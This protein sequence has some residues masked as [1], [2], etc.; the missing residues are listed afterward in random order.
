MKF[1]K[2]ICIILCVLFAFPAFCGRSAGAGST[3]SFD[4]DSAEAADAIT[5]D[6]DTVFRGDANGDGAIS[7][8]DSLILKRVIASLETSYDPDGA[9]ANGDGD[10]TAQDCSALKKVISCFTPA[11]SVEIPRADVSFD[12]ENG[13]AVVTAARNSPSLTFSFPS[14]VSASTYKYAVI[15]Y[16]FS[17]GAA[18]ADIS[19]PNGTHSSFALDAS[20][21]NAQRIVDLSNE[22]LWTGAVPSCTLAT[23]L[24]TGDSLYIEYVAFAKNAEGAARIIALHNGEAVEDPM[25]HIVFDSAEQTELIVG[26]KNTTVSYSSSQNAAK[27]TVSP[28]AKDPQSRISFEGSTVS[29]DDYK[30]IVITYMV[31]SATSSSAT[32]SEFFLC[33]GD[34]TAPT[35]GYS[36]EFEPVKDG[37]YHYKVISL[38]GADYWTGDVHLIRLDI[39]SQCSVGDSIYVDSICLAGTRAEATDIG[40]ERLALR[41]AA[42][43]VYSGDISLNGSSGSINYFDASSGSNGRCTFSGHM[44]AMISGDHDSFNRFSFEYSTNAIIRGVAYY[45]CGGVEYADEFFLENTSGQTA[46]FRSIILPYFEEEYAEELRMIDFYTINTSSASLK[47]TSVTEEDYEQYPQT[48]L[49]LTGTNFKVGVDMLMGG[50]INYFEDFNDNNPAYGNLLNNHDVGRLV[51]QS[52]YGIDKAPYELGWWGGH[53]WQYNPVQGGDKA[54]NISRIVDF[55]FRG[56]SEFY[57][58]ARPMDWGQDNRIT[59]SYMENVYTLTDTYLKIYNIFVDFSGYTHVNVRQELPAFYTISAL[60]DFYYYAGSNPWTGGSLTKKSNL[61]FWGHYPEQTTFT[62]PNNSEFWS[63]WCDGNGYGIGLYVPN[64]FTLRA[65][66]HVYDGSTDPGA[67]STNYVSPQRNMTLICGKPLTYSYLITA[68]NV[69]AIRNVFKTNHG[70]IGNSALA[71]YN[72]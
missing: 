10:I 27:L 31:P 55:E 13:C 72:N 66:M 67:S 12:A 57:V 16:R 7:V 62:L 32:K 24:E 54:H 18:S 42:G 5:C 68:G 11:V 44:T 30:Y 37:I 21:E 3:V 64:V 49:Y 34:V 45:T 50:G 25:A 43:G 52:Y 8:K 70:L 60:K 1:K 40:L 19:F 53:S 26:T 63:A 65:G 22:A 61:P 71:S 35:A 33:A 58:K 41:G 15:S 39:F 69:N 23:E 38:A 46:Q 51:Q 14:T 28:E 6:S 59:P 48:T 20:G 36:A 47:I 29:A 56:D 17:S 2:T 4:V 9:D